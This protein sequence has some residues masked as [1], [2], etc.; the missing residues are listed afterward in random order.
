M[1]EYVPIEPVKSESATSATQTAT[2]AVD[3]IVGAS[4]SQRRLVSV[5]VEGSLSESDLS[6]L[7]DA[8]GSDFVERQ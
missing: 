7:S 8:F 4:V 5:V 1:T 2:G 6:A 3:G